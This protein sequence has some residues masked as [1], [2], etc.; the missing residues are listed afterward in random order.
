MSRSLRSTTVKGLSWTAASQIARQVTN[1]IVSLILARLTGP[2]AYGLIGMVTIFTGF[3]SLFVDL[4]LG[5]GLIQ[6]PEIEPEQIASVFWINVLAGLALALSMMLIAPFAADFYH[7]PAVTLIMR[8]SSFGFVFGALGAVQL[9]L[10]S[11]ELRFPQI[12]KVD[13]S[14]TVFSGVLGIASAISGFGVWSLVLQTLAQAVVRTSGLWMISTWRPRT[15][16]RFGGAKDLAFFSGNLF[17]FN[18]LNYCV[19]NLDNLLIGRYVG[20]IPLGLY[21]RAYQLM[22]LPVQQI[23]GVSGNVLFPAMASVQGDLVRVKGIYLRAIAA[24]HLVAAPIYAGLFAVAD[25]F[26]EVVL[27][28]AW[29]GVVPLLRILCIVGFFQPVGSSTGWIYT[30]LGRSDIMM[31]WGVVTAFLY[32]SGFFIGLK[33]GLIGVTWSYCIAGLISWYPGWTFSGK[34][35]NAKFAEMLYPLLPSSFCALLMGI[36]VWLVGFLSKPLLSVPITLLIQIVIGAI[37]Y[38]YLVYL[39]R[40]RAWQ[41][42]RAL[43][44]SSTV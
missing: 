29:A 2:E 43:A 27:G 5:S 42:V 28:D 33:W 31:K 10:L 26:V 35:I 14:A 16:P 3:A 37:F 39:S 6:R 25:T 24:M 7:E 18:V 12:A 41:D 44:R 22:L 36:A 17:L 38:A 9:S 13:I 32:I 30:A 8:V 23:T 34:L 20:T 21:S 1:I 4:G 11:R 15:R 19:R 40:L